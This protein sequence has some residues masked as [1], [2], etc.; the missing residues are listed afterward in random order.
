[1]R[2]WKEFHPFL[3]LNPFPTPPVPARRCDHYVSDVDSSSNPRR[4]SSQSEISGP[5]RT[6]HLAGQCRCGRHSHPCRSSS[7]DAPLVPLALVHP[8][9]ID[10]VIS[11]DRKLFP[12]PI[13]IQY[14]RKFWTVE[15]GNNAKICVVFDSVR[16][17][18]AALNMPQSG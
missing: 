2:R 5:E 13:K 11:W 6:H 7:V 9:V 18:V 16:F 15:G 12:V 4:D 8:A 3:V 10:R 1:M 17:P 14:G